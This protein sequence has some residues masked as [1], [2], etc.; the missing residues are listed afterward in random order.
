MTVAWGLHIGSLGAVPK[1]RLHVKQQLVGLVHRLWRL[2]VVTATNKIQFR[3]VTNLYALI[4]MWQTNL[5]IIDTVIELHSDYSIERS[6][7]LQYILG[8]FFDDVYMVGQ[9]G[10]VMLD[11]GYCILVFGDN[12]LDLL[13]RYH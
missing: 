6:I 3:F 4:V 2:L 1:V 12:L 10:I 13:A 5:Q 11:I 8:I 9:T 7:V